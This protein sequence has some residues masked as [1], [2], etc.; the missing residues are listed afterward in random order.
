MARSYIG[1]R[2]RSQ[3]GKRSSILRRAT[4][5]FD[6]NIAPSSNG[7]RPGSEPVNGGSTPPGASNQLS[8][9]IH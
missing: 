2:L 5:L 3:R 7:K 6:S 1:N 4:K 9:S 8:E